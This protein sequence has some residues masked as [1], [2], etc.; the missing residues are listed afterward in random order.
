MLLIVPGTKVNRGTIIKKQS[1]VMRMN[2]I[3]QLLFAL[4]LAASCKR[5]ETIEPNKDVEQLHQRF[6]GKYKVVSSI[7]E[8]TRRFKQGR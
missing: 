2:F 3:G 4:L 8:P 7:A 6:H 5:S 1:A